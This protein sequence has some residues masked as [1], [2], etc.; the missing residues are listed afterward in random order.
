MK[1]NHPVPLCLCLAR[2][3]KGTGEGQMKRNAPFRC[4][5]ASQGGAKAQGRRGS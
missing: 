2:H 5:F 4:A 1:Q 3:G